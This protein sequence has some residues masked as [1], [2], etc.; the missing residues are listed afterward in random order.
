MR[1]TNEGIPLVQA[2]AVQPEFEFYDVSGTL[3]GFWT[4]KT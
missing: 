1:R 4:Q 2:V 3:V